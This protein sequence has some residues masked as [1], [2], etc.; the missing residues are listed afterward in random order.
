MKEI[1]ENIVS[2]VSRVEKKTGFGCMVTK[3]SNIDNKWLK[4]KTI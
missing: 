2:R 3:G 1:V 4:Y